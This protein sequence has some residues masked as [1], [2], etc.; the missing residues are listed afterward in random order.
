MTRRSE[1]QDSIDAKLRASAARAFEMLQ[2]TPGAAEAAKASRATIYSWLLHVDNVYRDASGLVTEELANRFKE[3]LDEAVAADYAAPH[4]VALRRLFSTL[5]SGGQLLSRQGENHPWEA[6]G[7]HWDAAVQTAYAKVGKALYQPIGFDDGTHY[8]PSDGSKLLWLRQFALSVMVPFK[9]A[10]EPVRSEVDSDE[11]SAVKL[12]PEQ[13]ITYKEMIEYIEQDLMVLGNPGRPPVTCKSAPGMIG[14]PIKLVEKTSQELRITANECNPFVLQGAFWVPKVAVGDGQ[15]LKEDTV[16]AEWDGEACRADVLA[17]L[18]DTIKL[19][20]IRCPML[21]ARLQKLEAEHGYEMVQYDQE[22]MAKACKEFLMLKVAEHSV[23]DS[24]VNTTL[25]SKD[26]AQAQ[27]DV[28]AAAIKA[29][30]QC[31]KD[32]ALIVDGDTAAS[33]LAGVFAALPTTRVITDEM[34]KDTPIEKAICVVLSHVRT[35]A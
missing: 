15:E 35:F 29:L 30:E 14:R 18:P 5:F 11:A 10:F 33:T 17:N 4:L 22:Q 13:L 23:R 24:V 25:V 6:T 2:E 26:A 21:D 34:P 19:A 28:V 27:K 3:W 8:V 20:R 7:F 1:R 9:P 12:T 32:G 16:L 31:V